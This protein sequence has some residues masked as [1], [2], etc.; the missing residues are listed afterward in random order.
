MKKYSVVVLAA[1]VMIG[2]GSSPKKKDKESSQGITK[3]TKAATI[4]GLQGLG[5]NANTKN[6]SNTKIR[7]SFSK[8]ESSDGEFGSMCQQGTM[9]INAQ[10]SQQKMTFDANNCFD[11][12]TNIDG[13]AAVEMYKNES[14]GF[15]KILSDLTIS[16][17]YFSLIAKKDSW[18]KLNISQ[19]AN[20]T[21]TAGFQTTINGE[22]LSADNLKVVT[23]EIGEGG[24]VHLQSGEFNIGEYYFKVNPETT[25]I[26]MGNDG[27]ISGV[28]KLTDGAGHK[29]EIATQGKDQIALKIDENGDGVFSE[30][31]I[32]VENVDD[33]ISTSHEEEFSS[34]LIQK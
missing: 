2:C 20:I 31:E 3:T 34:E 30:N 12:Y 18:I 23:K 24:S 14:G 8:A 19:G 25:P 5:D 27:F 17:D 11:G 28:I 15:A 29:V 4:A 9:D 13:F 10:E 22:K 21:L 1:L 16:D 26:V 32:S 7:S 6:L 33:L